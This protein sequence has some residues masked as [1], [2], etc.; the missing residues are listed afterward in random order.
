[1]KIVKVETFQCDAGWRP[2]LFIKIST[3]EGIHGWS[4]CTDSH[5]S[6]KGLLGV[7]DD[8]S[9]LLIGEDP[10]ATEK[11]YWKL[12]SRTRQSIGS[13][14][15]K[16]IGGIE[17]AL[18]DIKAKSL[19]IPV[20]ELFGG[21]IRTHVPIYWS[22][23]GTTRVRAWKMVGK[24]PIANLDDVKLF[25]EEIENS[26]YKVIKTNIAIF[27]ETNPVIYMPGFAKSAGGPEL[28]T[29]KILLKNIDKYIKTLRKNLSEDIEIIL[30]LNFNFKTDG[31]IKVGKLLEPYE[32][33]WLE[34][35]T[36]DP[37]ALHEIKSSINLP[38]CSGENLYG[39]RDYKPFFEKHAMDVASVD[40]IWN[41][42]AQSKKI[43]DMAN[44]YEMNVTPHNY[45][46]HLST[47]ISAHFCAAVPN[48]NIMEADIDDVPWK[49]EL[50]TDIPE[51][52]N[53][54][55]KLSSKPGW[56]VD[57]NE[58]VLLDHSWS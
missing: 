51:V 40:V 21:P 26:G 22:H 54:T 57:I 55:M 43:S 52:S 18:L 32:L 30:D 1:M 29:S 48:I 34:L 50:V 31:Y 39:M 10:R 6:P 58:K 37:V 4:E 16:A 46:S 49:D 56:G 12:F 14:I 11:L 15:Q 5:G 41:G 42:F 13:I 53:G 2:W 28:N 33:K 25:C 9:E 45:Y 44:V 24:E 23:C 36:Y 7:I 20:Y 19:G 38:I 47:F 35:D 8:L 17:N 3:D 27:D